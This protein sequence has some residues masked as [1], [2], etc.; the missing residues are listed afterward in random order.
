MLSREELREGTLYIN[1]L[2]SVTNDSYYERDVLV[3]SLLR[4]DYS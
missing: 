4:V 1:W 3:T 2:R